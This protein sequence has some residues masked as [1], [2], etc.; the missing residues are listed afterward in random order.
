MARSR[1]SISDLGKFIDHGNQ[2]TDI[3]LRNLQRASELTRSF[4]QVAFYQSSDA[5]RTID[6]KEYIDEIVL[7]LK[8]K[9]KH[10]RIQLVNDCDP[11]LIIYS[12][13]GGIYQIISNLVINALIYAFEDDQNGQIS[14]RANRKK[15]FINQ[16]VIR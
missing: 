8:P 7:S 13:P 16:D 5:W 4:K 2:A 6:L 11:D 3:L 14:I 12:H 1:S 9:W 10:T 15:D